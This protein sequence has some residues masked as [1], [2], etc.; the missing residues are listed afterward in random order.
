MSEIKGGGLL[1]KRGGNREE[2]EQNCEDDDEKKTERDINPRA[3]VPGAVV[4]GN[5]VGVK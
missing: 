2:G 3:R 5:S 4:A 1:S